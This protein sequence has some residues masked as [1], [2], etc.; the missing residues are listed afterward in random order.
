MTDH[1]RPAREELILGP[2]KA[3]WRRRPRLRTVVAALAVLAVGGVLSA[4]FLAPQLTED[5]VHHAYDSVPAMGLDWQEPTALLERPAG[6]WVEALGTGTCQDSAPALFGFRTPHAVGGATAQF[7]SAQQ[8]RWGTSSTARYRDR[9]SA[10]ADFDRLN[11]SLMGCGEFRLP[12]RYG[13]TTVTVTGTPVTRRMFTGEHVSYRLTSAAEGQERSSVLTGFRF[14]N[15]ITWQT[16]ETEL[17]A[18]GSAREA[19]RVADA[20]LSRLRSVS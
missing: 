12:A 17:D 19:D 20:V 8:G 16:F 15:S 10:A 1:G 4:G 5:E 9:E 14:A 13:S 11:T 6:G 18:V 7:G 2:V 3:P